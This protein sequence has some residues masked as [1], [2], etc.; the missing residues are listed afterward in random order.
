VILP[1]IPYD[2]IGSAEVVTSGEEP[3]ILCCGAMVRVAPASVARMEVDAEI[4]YIRTLLP[5]DVATPYPHAFEWD[6]FPGQKRLM[7]AMEALLEEA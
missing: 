7:A 3:T 2:A 5:L 4:I 6:Y 1:C